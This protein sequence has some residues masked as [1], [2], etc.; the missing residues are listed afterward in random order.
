MF[1]S[2]PGD[3]L[4][5]PESPCSAQSAKNVTGVIDS[6]TTYG[7]YVWRF[8][9][10]DKNNQSDFDVALQMQN[11]SGLR[12]ITREELSFADGAPPMSLSALNGTLQGY[13]AIGILQAL[14]RLAPFN[15]PIAASDRLIVKR[16]FAKAGLAVGV[17]NNTANVNF[18]VAEVV[19]NQSVLLS[20]K[21]NTE[22]HGNGW[23]E[24]FADTVGG[25][26]S[27]GSFA[28]DYI[29]R[30]YIAQRLYLALDGRLAR[31]PT[32]TKDTVG[33]NLNLQ[34]GKEEA[35]LMTFSGKPP[36]DGFWSVT[37]YD[38]NQY[39]IPNGLDR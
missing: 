28:T 17:Y 22:D 21:A 13:S 12:L 35:Y 1:N 14:A 16:I 19:A 26:K 3:Y 25:Y 32:Y 30:S 37:A 20:L 6:P 31:Y 9:V 18:T 4:L 23:V 8:F 15:P 2:T 34:I 27:N 33:E 7:F 39:L 29:G 24:W 11:A 10:K 38:E 36:V 5:R